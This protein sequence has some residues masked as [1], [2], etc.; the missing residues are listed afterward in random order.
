MEEQKSPI[1]KIAVAGIIVIIVGSI[2]AIVLFGAQGFDKMIKII[3]GVT[4][5]GGTMGLVVA[6]VIFIF[7][8][9]KVDVLSVRN[10]SII[11][12][13]KESK[14][15]IVQEL[16][17]RGDSFLSTRKIG[18]V[19]GVC[20]ATTAPEHKATEDKDGRPIL[21]VV[22]NSEKTVVYIAYKS[23]GLLS[24]KPKLFIAEEGDIQ[25]GFKSLSGSKI[26]LNGTTYAAS[27]YDMYFLSYHWKDTT[28]VDKTVIADC[29]RVTLQEYLRDMKTNI[30]AA[31][32][33]DPR[34]VKVKEL[35]RVEDIPLQRR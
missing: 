19:I 17:F 9:K 11:K 31:I 3:L 33:I 5:I 21:K 15:P 28:F 1:L 35:S 22:P 10:K 12:S 24:G 6:I 2:L 29:Q 14:N 25:G 18:K 34:H 8:K 16:W 27:L 23:G 7:S 30:D 20:L 4:L 32:D 13:C 26:F